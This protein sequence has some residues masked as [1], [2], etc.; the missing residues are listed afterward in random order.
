M[1]A[2]STSTSMIS[3]K[4]IPPAAVTPEEAGR[5]IGLASKTLANMRTAGTGP[6]YVRV[7]KSPRSGIVYR[8]ADLDAWL[9]ENLVGGK[10]R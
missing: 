4:A 1:T 5:Y 9:E 7:S 2:T 6:R 10:R 3:T 8:I